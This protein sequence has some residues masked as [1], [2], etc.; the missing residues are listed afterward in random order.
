MTTV[1]PFP[2]PTAHKRLNSGSNG[3]P[4]PASTLAALARALILETEKPALS[5]RGRENLSV[6]L[7]AI[8][9]D[10]ER[11]SDAFKRIGYARGADA[12]MT[13]AELVDYVA[14]IVDSK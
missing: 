3:S 7:E 9:L 14:K 4:M 5:R 10:L 6:E 8:V 11:K 12:L 1:I 2:A 13:A